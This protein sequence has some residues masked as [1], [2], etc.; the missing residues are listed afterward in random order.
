L[1]AHE[2]GLQLAAEISRASF[3][4]VK[5]HFRNKNIAY[6]EED[7]IITLNHELGLSKKVGFRSEN[8]YSKRKIDK[9]SL[10]EDENFNAAMQVA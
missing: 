9:K 2:I 3:H 6:Y 4:S 1:F 8:R 7:F 10:F 5:H